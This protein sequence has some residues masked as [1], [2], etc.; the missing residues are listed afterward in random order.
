MKNNFQQYEIS[1]F[2]KKGFASKHNLAYWSDKSYL[3]FGPAAAGYFGKNK[4]KYRYQNLTNLQNWQTN[5]FAETNHEIDFILTGL[6][7]TEGISLTEFKQKFK[8]TFLDKYANILKKHRNYFTI[9]NG[10][11]KFQPSAY[12]ISNEIL[13]EFV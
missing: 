3:G 4:K 11:I 1:N 7:K 10:Y 12:F 9:E 2:S 13:M 8:I 5:D 6:R